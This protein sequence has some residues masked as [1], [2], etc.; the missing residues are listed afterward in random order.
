MKLVSL[1]CPSCGATLDIGPSI[2]NFACGFCASNIAVE[3]S[4]NIVALRLLNHAIGKVQRGTDRTAA[5][6]AIRRLSEEINQLELEKEKC[7]KD[8]AA[9]TQKY[10]GIANNDSSVGFL[11]AGIVVLVVCLAL[12]VPPGGVSVGGLF[13]TVVIAGFLWYLV[14]K[15]RPELAK[16][17]AKQIEARDQETAAGRLA[18]Q[19][20]ETKLAECKQ[21]L[22]MQQDIVRSA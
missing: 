9:I 17:K 19:L 1:T 2:D 15:Q 13:A 5:E 7:D 6:L 11:R 3:R 20:A 16:L 14:G 4:G 21:T 8:L 10:L 12:S 18:Q 22:Q